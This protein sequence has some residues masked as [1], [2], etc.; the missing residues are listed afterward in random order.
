MRRS[1]VET[2]VWVT[3]LMLVACVV[4]VGLVVLIAHSE[5]EK[6]EDD[7]CPVGSRPAVAKSM[8]GLPICVCQAGG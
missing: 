1:T 7:I 2:S 3:I 5:A 4:L 8:S 6:C